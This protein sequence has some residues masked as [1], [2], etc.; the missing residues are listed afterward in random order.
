MIASAASWMTGT[1]MLPPP[2]LSPSAQPFCRSGKNALMLVME[3][4]KLPPPMPASSPT[5]RKVGKEVPGSITAK[6]ATVG[7]SSSPAETTVQLRPPKTATAK[8]Y[9]TRT[10]APTSVTRDVSRN[11]SAG[12]SPYSG[13]MKSTST[14]HIVQTENPMCSERTEK[15]RFRRA[16][17]SPVSRQKVS[18][19]G[20]QCA[21]Q[22][23]PG[24]VMTPPRCST[25]RWRRR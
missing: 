24:T 17:R 22:R 1:P 16:V 9:G 8:V 18:S 13:P 4:A 2:A 14:D 23:P 12:V 10:T 7:T 5:S 3:E 11:L 6:A 20:S 21:I 15:N 19:S 25:A